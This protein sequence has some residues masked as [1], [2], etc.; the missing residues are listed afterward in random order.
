MTNPIA[1]ASACYDADVSMDVDSHAQLSALSVIAD[2]QADTA[3]PS[4]SSFLAAKR[5][6]VNDFAQIRVATTIS[7]YPSPNEM[8][9][10]KDRIPTVAL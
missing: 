9:F 10:L 8:T 1:I 6:S 3:I 4:A 5:R 7:H 2:D